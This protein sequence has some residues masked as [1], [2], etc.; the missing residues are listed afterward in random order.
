KGLTLY[1]A[2]TGTTRILDK[3]YGGTEIAWS[4]DGGSVAYI[5]GGVSPDQ[6]RVWTGALRIVPLHGVPRTIV[7]PA[8]R[9]GGRMFSLAW[10]RPARTARFRKPVTVSGIYAGGPVS[11][12][13][14][15]AQN[16][17]FVACRHAYVWRPA[18]SV[19]R[20]DDW[21]VGDCFAPTNRESIYD[22]A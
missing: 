16:I 3:G 17:A 8:T 4:P 9:Y 13:A 2:R 14:A 18:R 22:L 1:D 7:A 5:R 10:T 20:Y 19:T 6:L 12:L 11:L 15:A 21:P